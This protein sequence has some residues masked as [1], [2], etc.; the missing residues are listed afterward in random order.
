M[1][2]AKKN[3]LRHYNSFF[4]GK[5]KKPAAAKK[6]IQTF[7]YCRLLIIT[8]PLRADRAFFLDVGFFVYCCVL[9]V[10][11]GCRAQGLEFRV[12][13]SHKKYRKIQKYF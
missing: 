9:C 13:F 12:E 6:I 11:L 4:T 2:K 3:A 7:L 10:L 5:N 1:K 8:N